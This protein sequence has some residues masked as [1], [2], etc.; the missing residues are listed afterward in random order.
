VAL[1]GLAIFLGIVIGGSS[2]AIAEGLHIALKD[3]WDGFFLPIPLDRVPDLDIAPGAPGYQPTLAGGH[4]THFHDE[5][6]NRTRIAVDASWADVMKG[7][8]VLGEYDGPPSVD[9]PP[10]HVRAVRPLLAMVLIRVV[11][12]GDVWSMCGAQRVGPARPDAGQLNLVVGPGKVTLWTGDGPHEQLDVADR[13]TV[14]CTLGPA[15]LTIDR[16]R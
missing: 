9:V 2:G 4:Q 14:W 1:V 11:G 7:R 13:E 5:V 16:R 10:D 8:F 12:G 6:K 3:G 15:G